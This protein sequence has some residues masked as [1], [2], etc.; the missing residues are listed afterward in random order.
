MNRI[1]FWYSTVFLLSRMSATFLFASTIN[2]NSRKPL[3]V[4]RSIP[5]EGWCEE[6]QRFFNQI[7][8]DEGGLSGGRLFF[9]TRRLLFS[10][11]GI[12]LTY[13]LVLLQFDVA[14]DELFQVIDC[15][16]FKRN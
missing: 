8:D 16:G 2:E 7:K 6:L 12:L 13:V 10:L 4:L 15:N 5:T 3:R 9:M 11:A 14:N 1:Y